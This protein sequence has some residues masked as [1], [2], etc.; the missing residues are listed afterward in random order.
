MPADPGTPGGIAGTYHRQ[1][2]AFDASR[3]RSLYECPWLARLTEGLPPGAPVLDLGCGAGEPLTAYLAA[4]GFTVTG[5]DASAPMLSLA[6]ARVP[7][8]RFIEGDMRG[9]ALDTPFAAILAWDSFFHLTPE[10]QRALIARLAA[11]LAPGGRLLFT[12]G[13]DAG[14]PIGTVGGEPV[15][16]ASLSPA[17]Y[18]AA[19]EGAG[20]LPRLFIAEDP[21][22]QGRSLWLAERRA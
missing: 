15:Y 18:A 20:L 10:D 19:L 13:P 14:E 1:A 12:C 16:H 4:Q 21:A 2:A 22:T 8:A 6:R 17:G 11:H 3:D 9:L 5:L 7:Q